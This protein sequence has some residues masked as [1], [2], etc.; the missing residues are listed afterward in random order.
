[1]TAQT[2]DEFA[3]RGFAKSRMGNKTGAV[4]D[5]NQ[6]LIINPNHVRSLINRAYNFYESGEKE[7]ALTTLE[8]HWR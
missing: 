1:M 5:Y 3:S 4:D 6:A 7:Q 2:A 8:K